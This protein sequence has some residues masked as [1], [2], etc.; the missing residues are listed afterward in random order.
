M[1]SNKYFRKDKCAPHLGNKSKSCYNKKTLVELVKSYNI[2]KKT[3]I[4]IA[5]K[6]KMQ[7]WDSLR[8]VL[9]SKCGNKEWCW[10][11]QNFAKDIKNSEL[12]D[13]TF[14][15]KMPKSWLKNKHTW[16]STTDINNVMRQYERLYKGFVFFGPV[17]VDCPFGIKCMLTELNPH[18]LK[19]KENIS[20]IGIIYNLDKHNEPGSHWVAVFIDTDN[21][22]VNYYDSYGEIPPKLIQKF[23]NSIGLK[24]IENNNS[25]SL[26]YNDRRHQYGHSECG[27][28]SMN[29][30]I[31]RLNGKTMYD[32]SQEKIP[33]KIMNK[34]RNYFYRNGFD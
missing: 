28:F 30:L 26:I 2:G 21:N 20:R 1:N 32:I 3:K 5:G 33:D 19:R 6:T 11:D 34:L 24:M 29:F 10:L 16:L 4:K 14:R 12:K 8:S 18:E 7:L 17:P 15:P 23:M 27:I 25:P 9:S 31:Q 13:Y 22:E